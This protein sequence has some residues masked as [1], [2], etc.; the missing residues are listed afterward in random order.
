MVAGEPGPDRL[1]VGL[2]F[3][4]ADPPAADGPPA[5]RPHDVV[6]AGDV[7][8]ISFGDPGDDAP[9]ALRGSLSIAARGGDG[10]EL[11]ARA[12]FDPATDTE[13]WADFAADGRLDADVTGHGDGDGPTPG[14]VG[15]AGAAVAATV[16]LAP[17]ERRSIRFAIAWDLPM[18]EFGAGRRWWKRYTRDWGRSGRRAW[19][20][21]THALE[22]TPAWRHRDRG[23]AGAL[24]RGPR[25]ARLVQDGAV[26]RAVLPR[27]RRHVLG[28]R[29]GRRSRS[30]PADHVGRFALLECLDYPFYDTVDVDFYASF[31]MLE[32]FPELELRGIRDLLATIPVDDPETVDDRGV[33]P[34]GARARSAAPSPTTSAGPT[35]TRSTGPTAT[36][37]RT[38]AAGRTSV[39]S[40]CSRPGAT[41]WPPVPTATR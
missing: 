15:A 30:P 20:L 12:S 33:R 29:R 3:T 8:G 35:T 40:S 28:G 17:G 25:A 39:R 37:S 14:E 13:L 31:A 38:S 9:T 11:S 36:G 26:Q 23:L 18:V 27:R 24:P 21:A 22:E 5:R 10:I 19:D 1:T 34:V 4:W 6:R 41:R 16:V 32:L 2:M 7:V